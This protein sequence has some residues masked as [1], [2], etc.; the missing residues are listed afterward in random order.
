M[1]EGAGSA[2]GDADQM[3]NRTT[4][5]CP[6]CGETRLIEPVTLRRKLIGYVCTVC[7]RTWRVEDGR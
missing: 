1:T 4:P 2:R 6:Y 3:L 5:R 7:A